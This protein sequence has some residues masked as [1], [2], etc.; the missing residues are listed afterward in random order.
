[1]KVVCQN[2]KNGLICGANYKVV[3]KLDLF[4]RHPWD[5][6]EKGEYEDYSKPLEVDWLCKKCH[7]KV[8]CYDCRGEE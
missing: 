7:Q 6:C 3:C 2:C 8:Y 5:T 1:M 4:K